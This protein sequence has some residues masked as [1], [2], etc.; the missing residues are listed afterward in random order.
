MLVLVSTIITSCATIS[1]KYD[2]IT[3]L[4]NNN[5]KEISK[6]LHK[7]EKKYDKASIS[8]KCDYHYFKGCYFFSTNMLN[9]AEYEF[10]T[11]LE[12]NSAYLSALYS[13]AVLKTTC[14]KDYYG[15]IKDYEQLKEML[16]YAEE[17]NYFNQNSIITIHSII[18]CPPKITEHNKNRKF[19]SRSM[20]SNEF[21]KRCYGRLI[22]A[23]KKVHEYR[24]AILNINNYL[25]LYPE[26]IGLNRSLAECYFSLSEFE[27]SINAFKKYLK[28]DE[29]D[30]YPYYIIG[31]CYFNLEDF[32]KC[33]E[34]LSISLEIL[35]QLDIEEYEKYVISENNK[36]L[37]E[38]YLTTV[39]DLSETVESILLFRSR[40]FGKLRQYSKAISDLSEIIV[41]N[42]EHENALYYRG[43]FYNYSGKQQSALDDYLKVIKLNP[44]RYSVNYS[45]ALIY[46]SFGEFDQSIAYYEKFISNTEDRNSG[47][48][49]AAIKR[50]AKLKG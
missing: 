4:T 38:N 43:Y 33:I 50:L 21:K 42:P 14:K 26:A 25:S 40:S 27:N 11:C 10:D 17:N 47:K 30:Y 2:I 48:Y 6:I 34:Q 12:L 5:Y 28:Q 35:K 22:Y 36:E 49:Q 1:R 13:R 44:N 46:D 32:E 3:A 7:M 20:Q 9:E 37:T 31:I 29:S 39:Q 18:G 45:I 23:Y 24:K 8:Q 19:T 15:A 16:F 41:E